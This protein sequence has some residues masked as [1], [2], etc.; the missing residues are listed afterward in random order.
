MA[1]S[2]HRKLHHVV[3]TALSGDTGQ[4]R[5]MT[6]V[7]AISGK[8]VGSASLWMGETH[9]AASTASDNH[10]HGE[11]ETAIY[12]VRGNPVFVFYDEDSGTEKRHE[13]KA[14]DYVFVPPWVPHREEN[15]D[16]GNE[17]VVVIART[18]QEAIVVNLPSLK[19]SVGD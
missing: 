16:P 12:V 15:P 13:T 14:G 2:F 18:T 9:V 11:S 1:D 8:T 19:P 17:A 6:R 5:G 3:P 10:H 7:E 4:T